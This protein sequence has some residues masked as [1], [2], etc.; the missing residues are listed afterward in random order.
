MAM[1]HI[2]NADSKRIY[3]FKA[4]DEVLKNLADVCERYVEVQLDKNFK[5]LDFYKSIKI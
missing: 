2:V 4:S 3:S 1:R 5:T